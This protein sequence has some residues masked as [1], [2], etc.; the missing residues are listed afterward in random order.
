MDLE[1]DHVDDN[2]KDDKASCSSNK[3]ASKIMDRDSHI[4]PNL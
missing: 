4:G 3:M 1:H 2:G